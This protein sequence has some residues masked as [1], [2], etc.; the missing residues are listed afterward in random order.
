[1]ADPHPAPRLRLGRGRGSGI[2][3]NSLTPV[4]TSPIPNTVQFNKHTSSFIDF[5][6]AR[7]ARIPSRHKIPFNLNSLRT[8]PY[9]A[10]SFCSQNFSSSKIMPSPSSAPALSQESSPTV[11]S[12]QSSITT[13]IPVTKRKSN[14]VVSSTPS[15]ASATKP[16]MDTNPFDVLSDEED[17][18]NVLTD[19]SPLD[20]QS[21]DQH[22][23]RPRSVKKKK[24][25]S[26]K[27]TL[28]KR[29]QSKSRGV[30][31]SDS[32]M[33]SDD[34]IPTKRASSSKLSSTQKQFLD[35][36]SLPS[37]SNSTFIS[38]SQSVPHPDPANDL[39]DSDLEKTNPKFKTA[40]I[41][42]FYNKTAIS[43]SKKNPIPSREISITHRTSD[44]DMATFPPRSIVEILYSNKKFTS[45]IYLEHLQ[46]LP[47]K[48]LR[49]Q[50]AEYFESLL[51]FNHNAH[52]PFVTESYGFF[53]RTTLDWEIHSLSHNESMTI[54]LGIK[55]FN[56]SL[57]FCDYENLTSM[58]ELLKITRDQMK[59][60]QSKVHINLWTYSKKEPTSINLISDDENDGD[61]I[62]TT[63]NMDYSTTNQGGLLSPPTPSE[64]DQL[65]MNV[66]MMMAT[67]ISPN[68]LRPPPPN[69][70]PATPPA[71]PVTQ[72]SARFDIYPSN[73]SAINVP[74][75]ARQLF[76]L[77]KKA[78]RTLR[79]L[80]WF[81]DDDNDV[82]AI[83]QEDDLPSSENQV[84]Q[85][86]DNPHIR[87]NRLYF[88]MR[89][90]CI[91]TPKHIRD[92]FVPWMIKNQ[93]FI[94]LD[95]LDAQEIYGIGFISDLHPH[96]YNRSA[97]KRFLI[98]KLQEQATPVDINVYVRRVWNSHEKQKV[99]S[100]AVV[101]EV[102]KQF[103]DTAANA[104]MNIDFSSFYRYAKFIPFNKSI[105]DDATLN[106]ILMSNNTYQNTTKRRTVKGLTS[107][108]TVH[109]THDNSTISIRDWLLSFDNQQ[110]SPAHEHIFEHV[111]TSVDGDLVLIFQSHFMETVNHFLNHFEAHLRA[112]FV[113]SNSLFKS[114]TP[115]STGTPLTLS[116]AEFKKKI[117][118]MYSNN[119]QDASTTP[120]SPPKPKKLYY[121]AADS[122]P[123]TYLN[124]LMQPKSPPKTKPTKKSAPITPPQ[125]SPPPPSTPDPSILARLSHLEKTTSQISS[126][127][128]AR[129][130]ELAQKK[131]Q[132]QAAMITAV[133]TTVTQVMTSSLPQ[134]IADQLK[135]A[136]TPS[137]GEKL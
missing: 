72:F 79:L 51:Q 46:S 131:E 13:W 121:G 12:S 118:A 124:H 27:K 28:K 71:V 7:K 14:R 76:R 107:I 1:M 126:S 44:I 115:F 45:N 116:N 117:A 104:L 2:R 92:T 137:D 11:D 93:S 38:Q 37:H 6:S 60:S 30:L 82:E 87:N 18:P 56:K 62:E 133:T 39:I 89:I 61:V 127:I 88:S 132:E 19:M 22:T 98:S 15:S 9:K 94:K 31:P 65:G 80:P 66:N 136:I 29:R 57:V 95:K 101:I 52:I 35:D 123:D 36:D 50:F 34:N 48:Q 8:F 125:P 5:F 128:D 105:V 86:V 55:D 67:S 42:S 97:L 21:D 111:E 32:S 106:N 74:L 25:K 91:A 4:L 53:D 103:K 75:V 59:R 64:A 77:F 134:L 3:V 112:K 47:Y 99:I 78:D 70:S 113:D 68:P 20:F 81:K 63:L 96:L 41:R 26:S 10:H 119:P 58:H 84:K 102:D 43:S 130:A 90:E 83:D 85:W 16:P 73:A 109:P 110:P 54:I 129:F 40:D 49:Q 122:A 24:K 69:T 17:D 135:V 108:T 120:I 33:E 100:R 23:S 114:S